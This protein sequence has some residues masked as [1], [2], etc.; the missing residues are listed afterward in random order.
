MARH[1]AAHDGDRCK[2]AAALHGMKRRMLLVLRRVAE[3]SCGAAT[4]AS[5]NL[6]RGFLSQCA[7]GPVV[8]RGAL[9]THQM[10]T[11]TLQMLGH[12][13]LGF[14]DLTRGNIFD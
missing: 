1:R 12:L 4:D 11:K 5:G 3:T 14:V 9:G 2:L 13:P 8:G 7:S 10:A 6:Q